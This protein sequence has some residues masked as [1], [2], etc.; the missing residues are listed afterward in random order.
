M[1]PSYIKILI[2]EYYEEFYV[3]KSHNSMKLTNFQEDT[4]YQSLTQNK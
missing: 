1:Y 4:N 3:K 2:S